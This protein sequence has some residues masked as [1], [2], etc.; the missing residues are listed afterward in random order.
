[1]TNW[2]VTT[3]G[4]NDAYGV[5]TPDQ[6][7]QQTILSATQSRSNIPDAKII[8]V[9]GGIKPLTIEQQELLKPHFDGFVDFTT[10]PTIQFAHQTETQNAIKNGGAVKTICELVIIKE[11]LKQLPINDN[12][13]VFKMTGR[14]R[15]SPYFNLN[16]HLTRKGKYLF[17]DPQEG[18]MFYRHDGTQ[19]QY[20]YQYKTRL[21]SFC[22]SIIN[23]VIQDFENI[24]N[25][26]VELYSADNYIDVEH[27]TYKF[28]DRSRVETVSVIGVEG[29]PAPDFSILME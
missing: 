7:L 20:D 18:F 24:F 19:F 8:L 4:I 21:Y 15:P 10:H 11:V 5:Y 2:V 13:R 12:D 27:A 17:K 1:M 28:I 25:N 16:D 9:E 3:S 23:E 29:N 26:T 14:Y 22:G 6:R